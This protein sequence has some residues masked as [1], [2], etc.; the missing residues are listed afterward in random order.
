[1]YLELFFIG[2]CCFKPWDALISIIMRRL[3][4]YRLPRLHN[5]GG[6]TSKQWWVE[7]AYR[8]PRDGKMK[9]KRYRDGFAKLKTR[10]ARNEFAEKLI[11]DLT[12]RLKGG[13]NPLDDIEQ[14]AYVD[15][16][17]YHQAA[18]VYGRKRESI[19]NIHFYGSEYITLMKNTKAKKTFE[20]YRG[21]IR[22][23]ISWLEKEKLSDNDLSTIDSNVL[24]RFFDHLI[25]D[26]KLAGPTIEKYRMTINSLF[27]YLIERKALVKNPMPK[28][29]IPEVGE[30]CAAV[31][32]LDEDMHLLLNAIREED[33]QLYLAALLQYFCFI[34]PGDELLKLKVGQINFAKRTIFI[35]KDI[36]K[37][38]V[39][40]TMDIPDPLYDVLIEHGLHRLNKELLVIGQFGRPGTQGV[41]HNTLRMRFNKYR[42][43]M[44]LSQS[45]KWYSFKHTGAGKLLESG[46]SIAELMNQLGH[47]DITST[48]QY[49]K[50][51]FGE[52][53]EH[54]RT[55]F[56]APAGMKKP[57]KVNTDW[58]AGLCVN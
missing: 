1:M 19:K 41:G 57:V 7:I 30:D 42:D 33:P 26:Q 44:R 11:K 50:R 17:E 18:Q 2:D 52:R 56:P 37:V 12:D 53:S 45:Y 21:K 49:I 43:R 29:L 34:R 28:I 20:S 47:T 38:R 5:A 4:L 14:V 3:K 13:W 55:K 39:A 6:D 22:M 35:P 58:L 23:L 31:P 54:V 51:H 24:L 40:R 9:R 36:A 16:L 15:E 48:Y 10:K 46:A 25:I 27:S 8:D 32:F